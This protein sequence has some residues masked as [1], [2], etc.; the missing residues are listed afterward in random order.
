M[1]PGESRRK[2]QTVT[3]M[4]DIGMFPKPVGEIAAKGSISDEDVLRL[5]REVFRDGVVDRV[6]AE[7]VFRLNGL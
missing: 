7:A 4:N 6:E 5:R 1:P 2:R 3:Q